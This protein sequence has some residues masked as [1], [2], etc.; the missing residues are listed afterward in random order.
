MPIPENIQLFEETLVVDSPP[1]LWPESLKALWWDAKGSWENSH[2]IA[3][4]IHSEMGYWIH[5]YLHRKEGDEWNAG[6]WYQLA[7]KSFPSVSLDEERDQ[8]IKHILPG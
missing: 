2:N 3:Q 6:Y 7:N 8:L 4:E 5:A 1:E